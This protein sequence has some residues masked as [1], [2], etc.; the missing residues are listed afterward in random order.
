M[1]NS[2]IVLLLISTMIIACSTPTSK[3][4][5]EN[6]RQTPANA[7]LVTKTNVSSNAPEAGDRRDST[8]IIK[9]MHKFKHPKKLKLK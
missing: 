4:V 3:N 9:P 1:G 5:I 7:N 6:M 2:L 8:A